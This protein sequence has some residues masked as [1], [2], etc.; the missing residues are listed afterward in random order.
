MKYA[1]LTLILV[2]LFMNCTKET[3]NSYQAQL[4]GTWELRISDGGFNGSH[5]VYSSGNGNTITFF[6]TN[7]YT[8]TISS[9]NSRD[10]F[11][12]TYLITKGSTCLSNEVTFIQ[13]LP[14]NAS[15]LLSVSNNTLDIDAN[16]CIMADVPSFQY[17]KIK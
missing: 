17:E 16:T 14:D 9:G 1:I 7:Q 13:L 3:T 15:Y 5:N 12:S 2:L 11:T 10:T 4:S 6:G 8:K